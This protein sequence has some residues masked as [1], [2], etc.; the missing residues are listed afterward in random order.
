MA[1]GPHLY[2]YPGK[3]RSLNTVH[4]KLRSVYEILRATENYYRI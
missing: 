3:F 2:Y 1:F 4:A